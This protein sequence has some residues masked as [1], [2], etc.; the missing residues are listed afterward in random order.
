MENIGF[1]NMKKELERLNPSANFD[2]NASYFATHVIY[3][4]IPAN[5]IILP[6]GYYWKPENTI[7]NKGN[8]KSGYYE[9]FV[10][11]YD[12]ERF[13]SQHSTANPVKKPLFARIFGR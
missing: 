4:T 1:C 11:E 2:M 3:G 10:Y 7:T 8:T 6:K 9:Y 13:I 5:E 12:T